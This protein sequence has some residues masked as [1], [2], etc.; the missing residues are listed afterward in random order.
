MSGLLA[1]CV[2]TAAFALAFAVLRF[3]EFWRDD[4]NSWW[5]WVAGASAVG[6]LL[7]VW[8]FA[9]RTRRAPRAQSPH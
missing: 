3:S 1:F 9:A 6:G 8:V 4:S 7:G 5:L 2:G